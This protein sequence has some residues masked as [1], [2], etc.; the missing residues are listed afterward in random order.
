MTKKS[1]QTNGL[2]E[3]IA[4]SVNKALQ[5][6]G[7]TKK[8]IG[9]A[10]RLGVDSFIT[11]N[12]ERLEERWLSHVIENISAPL[13]VELP[14]PKG[15]EPKKQLGHEKLEVLAKVISSGIPSLMVGMP[16][17]G[18]TTAAEQI[19]VKFGLSFE[20]ISVG[21][22]TTKSDILGFVDAGGNYQAT[23]FR[24]AFEHGGLFLMD[25]VDAGN[26][27]VLIVINSAISNGFCN[28]PD[29]MVRAHENFRFVATANTFGTGADTK[30]IGRNQLDEATLDRF[31]VVDWPI[32]NKVE[33]ALCQDKEWL[34]R[35]RELRSRVREDGSD[36]LVSPR[37]TFY[38]DKLIQS[39]FSH[40]QAAEMTILKGKDAETV[41]YIK[42]TMGL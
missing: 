42:D 12:K 39:G 40:L 24:K 18:K 31:V 22:Q 32:D 2:N 35:V 28:F 20:S 14:D 25:E 3:F 36:I 38:G 29:K 26:P 21:I 33:E 19:A 7:L 5:E 15:G 11:T 34:S 13:L 30:F 9:A 37:V 16:G 17:T 10:V 1:E 4:Q 8:E 6:G 41:S 23:G 27:N